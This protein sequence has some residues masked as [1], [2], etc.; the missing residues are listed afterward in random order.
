MSNK[1]KKIVICALVVVVIFAFAYFLGSRNKSSDKVIYPP[2]IDNSVSKNSNQT[3][4]YTEAKNHEGEFANVAG[5]VIQVYTSK[6]NTTFF[7]FCSD[8]K[9]CGFE[10]VVFSSALSSFPNIKQYESKNVTVN[11]LIKDYQGN[12]EIILN[13]P[14][15]IKIN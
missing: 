1:N 4:D 8:C 3:Y 5:T 11:G 10:A 15:Q 2:P 9:N 14:E 6:S 12:A 7:D 13:S